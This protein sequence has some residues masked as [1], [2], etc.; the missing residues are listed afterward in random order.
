MEDWRRYE[1]QACAEHRETTG[2]FAWHWSAIGEDQLVGSGWIHTHNAARHRRLLKDDPPR[3]YGLDGLAFDLSSDTYHAIQAK[4]RTSA[5]LTAS[6]VGTFQSVVFNRFRAKNP[7]SS[8]FLYTNAR[9]QVDLRDDLRNGGAISVVHLLPE[10]IPMETVIPTLSVELRDYQ[11]DALCKLAEGWD[12]FG[13]LIMPCATGKTL[14][15]GHHAMKY[16]KILL[17]SPLR[18]SALQNLDR[19]SDILGKSY[20]SLLVDSD[21]GD[22]TRDVDIISKTWN[23]NKTV[24]I[25]TTFASAKDVI[26]SSILASPLGTDCLVVVDEAHNANDQL[27]K[28]LRSCSRVLLSTATPPAALR[29]DTEDSDLDEDLSDA[30]W[31][32]EPLFHYSFAEAIRAGWISDYEIRL[33]LIEGECTDIIGMQARFMLDAMVRTGSRKIIVY[34]TSQAECELYIENVRRIATDFHGIRDD[35]LWTQRITCDVSSSKRGDI[36]REFQETSPGTFCILASVRILDEA[37]DM[38]KCDSVFIL[39]PSDKE[40]SWR[41]MV[42]RLSRAIRL[43]SDN[44]HKVARIMLWLPDAAEIPMCFRALRD[45]DPIFFK[46]IRMQSFGVY[47]DGKDDSELT[48]EDD[49]T[50]AAQESYRVKALTLTEIKEM[51]IQLLIDYFIEHS[52]WPPRDYIAN[53]MRLGNYLSYMR[54]K[55]HRFSDEQKNKLLTL[56]PSALTIRR[57]VSQPAQE[58]SDDDKIDLLIEYY[59]ANG[60]WPFQRYTMENGFQLGRFWN[61]FRNHPKRCTDEQRDRLLAVDPNA[62]KKLRDISP[63]T[64]DQK[65]DLLIEYYRLNGKWPSQRYKVNGFN[66]GSFLNDHRQNPNRFSVAQKQKLLAIDIRVFHKTRVHKKRD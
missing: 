5:Y 39:H 29:A 46:K 65:I 34:C 49:T 40:G 41:R 44:P 31:A 50:T 11:R 18:A 13:S 9:L 2:Q 60:K 4:L 28:I 57:V 20:V 22:A 1:L 32:K 25:S 42:Q 52:R 45:F 30:I 63:M 51:K 66:L 35:N 15:F 54:A 33:P 17:I 53:N 16:N 23:E 55:P 61:N 19:V 47:D 64:T 3:E 21:G 37:I 36:L 6:D 56:D 62:L 7:Q 43:D 8:G 38:P 27:F 24:L 12:G 26:A 59:T 48:L 58:L 10:A 14:V